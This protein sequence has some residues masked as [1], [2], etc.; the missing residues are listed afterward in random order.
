MIGLGMLA[1][2]VALVALWAQ[3]RGRVPRSRW[4]ARACLVLPLL[5]MAANIFG[6]IFTEMGRQPWLVFGEML[7][8]DGVSR[9]VSLTEVLTS[10]TA[11]TLVYAALALIEVRL[12]VRYARAGLPAPAQAVPATLATSSKEA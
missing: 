4:L 5:P 6:W 7:T 2:A 12:L 8:R 11:F 1:A 9:S 10:F 3:R